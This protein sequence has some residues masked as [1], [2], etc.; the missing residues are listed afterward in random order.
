VPLVSL[1][2]LVW[3]RT[4]LLLPT[5]LALG[6]LGCSSAPTTP[7]P[8]PQVLTPLPTP[9]SPPEPEPGQLFE[10]TRDVGCLRHAAL[11]HLINETGRRPNLRRPFGTSTSGHTL[12]VEQWGDLSG[13]QVLVLTQVHGDECGGLLLAEAIRTHPPVGYGIWLV[14]TLN[15]DGATAFTRRTATNVDLNRDGLELTQ[16]ETRALMQLTIEVEPVLTL[17]VHSPYGWVGFYGGSIANRVATELSTQV[18]AAPARYAGDGYGF[19]WEGQARAL[20]AHPSVLLEFPALFGEEAASAPLRA[21]RRSTD[22][23]TLRT[24][25]LEVLEVLNSIIP[26]TAAAVHP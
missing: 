18:Y 10:E 13:P 6:I 2:T 22:L 12:W 4:H 24:M 23:P 17:H 14:P 11:P 21:E 25:T 7:A 3:V 9:T 8:A 20:P 5:L 1:G 26:S 16:P 19:L 15:P